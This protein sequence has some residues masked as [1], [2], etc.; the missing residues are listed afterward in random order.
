[1]Y[2]CAKLINTRRVRYFIEL[3]YLGTNFHGWQVQP[4]ATSVQQCLNECLSTILRQ[5]IHAVGAGRTDAGVHARQMYAH[6]D[7]TAAIDEQQMTF[8]LN[9]LLPPDIAIKR[10]IKVA[11][12]AHARFDASARSYEYHLTFAKN[13]FVQE[14]ACLYT[15]ELDLKGM[16]QATLTLF[17]YSDFSAFS[18]SHTQTKTNLCVIK[19]AYWEEVPNGLIFHITAD[20]FLR[21]MVRAIVGTLLEVGIGKLSVADFEKIIEQQDRTKAGE[22]AAAKGL[23]LTRVTYPNHIVHV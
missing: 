10:I 8:K 19:E 9:R 21:N 5:S 1:M 20:R 7:V 22:S 23:F 4:N 2:F 18:R 13:P 11:D 14:Q 3:S 16:E 17:N 6:F 15:R 12:D